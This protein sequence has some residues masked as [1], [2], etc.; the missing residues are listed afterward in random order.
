MSLM[1]ETAPEIDGLEI[2]GKCLPANTVSGDFFDYLESK[3]PNELAVVVGDVTGHGMKGAMNAVMTDGTLRM[4]AEETGTLSPASLMMKVNNVLT[5]SMEREMNVTMVIGMID[6]DTKTLTL[7]NAGHHA[8]PVL[9]RNGDIR[10]LKMGGFP[11]GM[12][13]GIQYR[14]EQFSLASGDIVIFMTDGII[15]VQDNEG[16]LYSDSG[17]LEKTLLSLQVERSN[18]E[19]MVDAIISDAMN[20][21]GDKSSRDTKDNARLRLSDDMTVVVVKIK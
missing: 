4:A 8:Y 18:P 9:L 11:L 3:Q 19:A 1:P 14:E 20:F 10:I 7:A 12:R 17:R 6:S 15:E 16:Q 2:A 21:G 13:A 5:G